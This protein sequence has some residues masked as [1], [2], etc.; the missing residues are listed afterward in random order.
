MARKKFYVDKSND[1]KATAAAPIWKVGLYIRLSREDG[2]KAVS[3]S[4]VNQRKMLKYFIDDSEEFTDYEYFIDENVTGTNFDRPA[5]KKMITKIEND[6]INCVIVKDLSRFGRDYLGAGHYLENAFRKCNCRFISIIDDVDSYINREAVTSLM[7]R[8]KNLAHDNNSQN[9]S[10]NVRRTSNNLR[11]QGKFIGKAPYGYLTDPNDKY[12]LVV[13][14]NVTDIIRNIFNWYIS[15]IG[16]VRIAKKLNALGV[17]TRADYKKSR[18]TY[19]NYETLAHKS[20]SPDSVLGIL[21]NKMY[22][23]T[24]V[25]RKFTSANYKDRRKIKVPEEEQLIM[26]NTHEAIITNKKFE[27]VHELLRKRCTKTG[28]GKSHVHLFAGYIKC[29]DCGYAMIKNSTVRRGKKYVYYKC[30]SNHHSGD[31]VCAYSHSIKAEILYNI[32]LT[33]LNNHILTLI[34]LDKL[35][36]Y[37]NTKK[38]AHQFSFDYDKAIKSKEVKIENTNH[39]KFQSYN[40][41]K[42]GEIS[43]D[44]YKYATDKYNSSLEELQTEI[45]ELANDKIAEKDTANSNY[46][47]LENIVAHGRFTELTREVLVST[48]D[49]IF[50]TKDKQIKIVFKYADEFERLV[51][52]TNINRDL[53]D[54]SKEAING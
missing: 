23:G 20:W 45:K 46:V 1:T 8:V 6:E 12:H 25:Q 50:V 15:G 21:A 11:A 17:S 9:I 39:L 37:I 5:F 36:K 4:V 30:R 38:S 14:P 52:Y 35:V 54:H 26:H 49:N 10:I 22:T 44:E 16:V 19:V 27:L 32:V 3:D 24:L 33:V 28:N 41:W 2:D 29:D 43:K 18:E 42:M 13:D 51:Q 48:I 7:V 34:E 31:M 47:W 40:S 53:T